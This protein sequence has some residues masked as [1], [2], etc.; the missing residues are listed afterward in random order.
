[1]VSVNFYLQLTITGQNLSSFEHR[2]YSTFMIAKNNGDQLFYFITK[3]QFIRLLF[4][5]RKQVNKNV[6]YG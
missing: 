3:F 1:M 2:E 5:N 6:K 4:P